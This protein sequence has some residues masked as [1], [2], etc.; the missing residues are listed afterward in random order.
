MAKYV[1]EPALSPPKGAC[2]IVSGS[3]FS[4]RFFM[5]QHKTPSP[6]VHNA[7]ATAPI[8]IPTLTPVDN[9]FDPVSAA[10]GDGDTAPLV[11]VVDG[12]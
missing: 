10:L 1:G 8:P 6:I 7:I 5:I 4:P 2:D 9:S 11:A 3:P 12:S